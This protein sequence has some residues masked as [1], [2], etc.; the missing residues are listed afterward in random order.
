VVDEPG[1]VVG[2]VGQWQ[3]AVG[4]ESVDERPPLLLS[5]VVRAVPVRQEREPVGDGRSVGPYESV[6]PPTC[7][8]REPA[9]TPMST[10]PACHT[11]RRITSSPCTRQ[12]ASRFAVLP[13]LT[14][15]TS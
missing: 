10:T 11:R 5:V 14:Q 7:Q 4:D 8:Q 13:P 6:V 9:E 12:S 1:T 15:I 2:G 3:R